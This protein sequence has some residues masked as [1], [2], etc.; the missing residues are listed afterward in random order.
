MEH[1]FHLSPPPPSESAILIVKNADLAEN[2]IVLK[3]PPLCVCIGV[4][5][6]LT[7]HCLILEVRHRSLQIINGQGAVLVGNERAL[8]RFDKWCELF[9]MGI[10]VRCSAF[11]YFSSW[12]RQSAKFTGEVGPIQK[13]FLALAEEIVQLCGRAN[14]SVARVALFHLAYVSGRS[15]WHGTP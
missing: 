11:S 7:T 9:R 12:T 6:S 5:P 1:F 4:P 2:L 14:P 3:F 15:L 13:M 8:E 10:D